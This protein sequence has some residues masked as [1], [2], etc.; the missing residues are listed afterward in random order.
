MSVL[1][2]LIAVVDGVDRHGTKLFAVADEH[3]RYKDVLLT[4]AEA[5]HL[6][7]RVNLRLKHLR[8]LHTHTRTATYLHHQRTEWRGVAGDHY[9]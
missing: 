4:A 7:H 1:P 9:R 5:K 6:H 3:L 2:V 8:Q